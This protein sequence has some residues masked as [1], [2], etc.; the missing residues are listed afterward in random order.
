MR[1]AILSHVTLHKPV[2]VTA[3]GEGSIEPPIQTGL[4]AH[5]LMALTTFA[6]ESDPM[7]KEKI[8]GQWVVL[9]HHPDVGEF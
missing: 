8:M 9:A 7:L 4:L 5:V 2:A 3:N 6:E 1:D